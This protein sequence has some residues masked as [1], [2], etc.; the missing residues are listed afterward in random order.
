MA[1]NKKT[2]LIWVFVVHVLVCFLSL[3]S[4]MLKK[5]SE[6]PI[7]SYQCIGLFL[8]SGFILFAYALMWQQ[9]L[10]RLPLTVAFSNKAVGMV[11]S[12]LWGFLFFGET[13]SL[14]MII[15]AAIVLVGVLL[16]VKSNE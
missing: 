7:L 1:E 8:G 10:K 3:S 2:K 11:W 13:I 12:M 4:V 15:G 9:V 5:A 16:V 6:F 14:Q